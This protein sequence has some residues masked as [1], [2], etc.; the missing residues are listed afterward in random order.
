MPEMNGYEA[1][2]EIRRLGYIVPIVAVTASAIKGEK[3]KCLE[4]GMTD[5]LTKPFKKK[6]IQPILLKWKGLNHDG[7][8]A[9]PREKSE[10]VPVLD[11]DEGLEELETIEEPEEVQP[12]DEP[13]QI[14][15][16]GRK[17]I[18]FDFNDAVETFLGNSDVVKRV[19]KEYLT[20]V[21][22][23]IPEIEKCLNDGDLEGSREYAHSIKGSALNLSMEVLGEAAKEL[24][25]SSR[26]GELDKSII[27]LDA[28]KTAFENLK[29]YIDSEGLIS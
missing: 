29:V 25:Y 5:F 12:S 10:V 2:A 18:V 22:G 13:P 15:E 6:D 9:L 27:N 28:V 21:E 1:T 24:E 17:G 11:Q 20:K 7:S 4:S 8:A 3:E 26:D 23:Q 14:D 16:P 19:L